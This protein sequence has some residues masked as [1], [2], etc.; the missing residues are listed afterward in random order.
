MPIL[1]I[2]N[3]YKT[4]GG[5]VAALNNVSLQVKEGEAVAIIGSSG[6]GKSTLLRCVNNLER[7]TAGEIVIDGDVLVTTTPGGVVQYPP[8][9]EIRR[10]TT[11]TGMVFQHFNLFAHL[12]CLENITFA[13][14]KILGQSRQQSLQKAHE[15]LEVVGLSS[16]ANNYPDQLSGGQQQRIAIARALAMD[17][18][19]MLFDEPTSALDPEITNE[20]TGVILKLV[21]QKIT[22]L[23]V[24]HDMRFARSAATRLIYMDEGKIVEQGPP[25]QLFENPQSPRLKEFLSSYQ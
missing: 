10:I 21:Q 2:N 23:I 16:K 11:K 6:S 25:E 14:I 24:T 13:P 4:F 15:L 18:Q 17:P 22:M 7:V 20:V 3:V 12:T 8:D 1:A 19:I 9:K 5:G